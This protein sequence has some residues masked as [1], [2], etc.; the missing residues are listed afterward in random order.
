[1]NIATLLAN[2]ARAQGNETALFH[3]TAPVRSYRDLA[4][5]AATLAHGMQERLGVARGD[6]ILL[7]AGNSPGYVEAMFAAWYAGAIIVPVNPALHAREVA[8][9]AGDAGAR[10]C[11]A[12]PD[13]T[14]A[15]A[16]L[17]PDRAVLPMDPATFDGL[18]G[19]DRGMAVAGP[20][21][22]AWIFYTSGTTGRP[23]GAMLSHGNLLTMAYAYL[24]DAD[25][26]SPADTFLHLAPQSHAAGL[27]MLA[28]IMKGARHVI[29]DPPGFDPEDVCRLTRAFGSATSFMSPTMLA[30]FI[31]TPSLDGDVIAHTRT[32]L[33][34]G[35]P[36]YVEDMKRAL[37]VLGPKV[38]N[39]YGQGEA[40]CTISA[41]PK[42]WAAD[43]AHPDFDRRLASV[44][45][46]RSGVEIAMRAADGTLHPTGEGEVAVRGP[47]VMHGYWNDL[48]ATQAALRDGWLMTGDVGVMDDD[49]L[50]TLKGRVKELIIS[51]GSNIYPREIEEVLLRHPAVTEAAV[52]G[53]P[54][55]EWG[56]KVVAFI[57]PRDGA[58]VTAA[59]LDAL[60]LDQIARFKRPRDYRFV[61][62]LPK[63]NAGKVLKRDLTP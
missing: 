27:L 42:A 34:G 51:G 54:D 33:C 22:I 39:G 30:R 9:I 57:V 3:G 45:I 11:L 19:D 35:A 60:C 6:R 48:A 43:T 7:W 62:A 36:I 14:A 16:A 26:L 12:G 18:R 32:I 25:F 44:G 23:K 1:M 15:L 53:A 4:R 63:N 56:E 2:T 24:A 21:D 55:A 38:W 13:R 17:L 5:A 28:H 61:P 37:A 40:P 31:A 46:A 41:L 47:I 58:A 20:S 59:D 52:V 50:L 49:G 10:L 29:P 8:S